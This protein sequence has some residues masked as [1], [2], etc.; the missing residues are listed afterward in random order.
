M[1]NNGSTAGK[2][3]PGSHNSHSNNATNEYI[4]DDDH[5]IVNEAT[6]DP[7]Q[8]KMKRYPFWLVTLGQCLLFGGAVAGIL[9]LRE[10]LL[11]NNNSSGDVA[12]EHPMLSRLLGNRKGGEG[13]EEQEHNHLFM[14]LGYDSDEAM[15][16]LLSLLHE[17]DLKTSHQE[18][19]VLS[20]M[21]RMIKISLRTA[22]LSLIFMP[23]LFLYVLCPKRYYDYWCRFFVSSLEFA[24]PCFIK[25]GQW[26]ATRPDLFS[27]ELCSHLSN[28]HSQAPMHSFRHTKRV[29]ESSFNVSMN[30]L[31]D[32]FEE[33]AIASGAIAQVHRA[34]LKGSNDYVAVKVRHPGVSQTITRDLSIIYYFSRFID[35]IETF[36]WLNLRENILSF[37]RNM[38][39]QTDLD[40]EA[41]SLKQFANNFKFIPMII[42][43]TPI[44]HNSSV[45]IESY[46]TGVPV[47][48]YINGDYSDSLRTRIATLGT[49]MYLKMMFV[50]N[51]VHSDLHPGNILV[52]LNSHNV[53][54]LVVL[55]TGMMTS[56]APT[57]RQNFIDLFSAII[58]GKS[59]EAAKLMIERGRSGDILNKDPEQVQKFKKEMADLI[60][61][62]MDRSLAELEVGKILQQALAVGR[63]YQVIL[64]P[65][66]TTLVIGTIII[67]GLG[68]RLNPDFNFIESA[69]PFLRNESSIKEA[70]MTRY[71]KRLNKG[72]L[73]A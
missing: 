40:I 13:D 37:S 43:P 23:S 47:T 44:M 73:V 59:E 6:I 7:E 20:T 34:K 53:P 14:E 42:F 56:L 29:I 64:E 25:L 69:K 58:A 17:Q 26:M 11:S 31:F 38:R 36:A 4:S 8:I 51:L 70:Y 33:H 67:E 1:M 35:R 22:Q 57:D 28:L 24:G 16:E 68:R 65:N 45:L 66:F 71:L 27:D 18:E 19:N 12:N 10:R 60:G 46:E 3:S 41:K 9:Y 39:A 5:G 52:R 32:M 48:E 15:E 49:N 63:K 2:W 55:D 21:V 62:V 72:N 61:Y 54:S 30:E 50:D